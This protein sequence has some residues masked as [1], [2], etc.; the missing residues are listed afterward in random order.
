VVLQQLLAEHGRQFAN[1]TVQ[2]QQV[3]PASV[4]VIF[5]VKEGPKIKVGKITFVGNKH[6]NS[7]TL[8]AAMK[9]LHPLGIPN[10][11]FLEGVF[12]K[13]FDS[14]KLEED[15]ERVRDAL[16]HHAYLPPPSG[17]ESRR[18]GDG[19]YGPD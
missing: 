4:S 7:R 2:V 14:S 17:P 9:N 19:H 8:R 10:S 13:T 12:A 16:Q 6:V 18:Q 5:N 15:A 11:I 1:I 3:P